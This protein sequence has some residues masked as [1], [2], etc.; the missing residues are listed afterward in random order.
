MRYLKFSLKHYICIA[1]LT[2]IIVGTTACSKEKIVPVADFGNKFIE[3]SSTGSTIS[4]IEQFDNK[5]TNASGYLWDFG[6]GS[7][8]NEKNPEHTFIFTNFPKTFNVT[9]QVTSSTGNK[10]SSTKPLVFN[11]F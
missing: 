8:S 1:F 5:S 9:L 2:L 10:N 11:G 3:G 4:I 7:T 6:D